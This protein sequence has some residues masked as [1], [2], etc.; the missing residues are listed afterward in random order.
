MLVHTHD[1]SQARWRDLLA[2]PVPTDYG[3][4][5]FRGYHEAGWYHARALALY[6]LATPPN[7]S[8]TPNSTLIA[9][10]DAAAGHAIRLANTTNV[11]PL[12]D[13]SGCIPAELEAVK[14]WRVERNRSKAVAAYEALVAA[15]DL[16]Q[17]SEPPSMYFAP[18]QCLGYA[19]LHAGAPARNATRALEVFEDDLSRYW[20][21]AWSLYGA[22]DA[23]KALNLTV[24][25]KNYTMMANAAWGHADA[26]FTSPCPQLAL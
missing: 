4:T 15:D 6:G 21:N 10:A 16:Q 13:L 5:M 12:F 24:Q 18:R 23:A 7:A 11:T 20:K 17:Y 22:A 1:S 2:E 19:L 25:A 14:A 3:T 8:N 9:Q 26:P